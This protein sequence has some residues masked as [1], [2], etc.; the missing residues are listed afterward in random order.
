M[1]AV[2]VIVLKLID[3]VMSLFTKPENILMEVYLPCQ[4]WFYI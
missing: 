2:L 3:N 4:S 1:I